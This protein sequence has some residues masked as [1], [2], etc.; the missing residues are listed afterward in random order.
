LRG[1]RGILWS[2]GPPLKNPDNMPLLLQAA[3]DFRY[4]LNRGYPRQASL[5]LVGNRYDLPRTARQILHRGVFA[6]ELA[7][8]RRA[9]LRPLAALAGAP[10]A[11]DGHNVLITLESALLGRVLV[12]ADDG[13]LRD[14]AQLSRAYRDSPA[15][16][17][18]LTLLAAYVCRHRPGPLTILYD[19]PMK[20][21]GELAEK[22]REIFAAQGLAAEAR[23]VPVPEREL[24]AS[25]GVVATSDTH[26]IDAREVVVDLAG[27]IIRK[28]LAGVA[29][30]F[31]LS[32]ELGEGSMG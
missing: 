20:R 1:G 32:S 12:V 5:T 25:P 2:P 9:K 21:S 7:Q 19:A 23:A 8:A 13:F 31:S 4:L 24:L 18:A 11:V 26:L 6:A 17:Q 10:L 3:A 15:T 22:T 30:L 27:E 14:V 28:E 16:R 29:R